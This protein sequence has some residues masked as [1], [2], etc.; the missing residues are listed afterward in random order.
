MQP[1]DLRIEPDS[2]LR[3]LGASCNARADRL[4]V[5]LRGN[6]EGEDG[7]RD[8]ENSKHCTNRKPAR[9]CGLVPGS[10]HAPRTM[11]GACRT[12]A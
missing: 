10:S 9:T 1:C 2:S 6:G 7:D 4:R 12:W 11:H 5:G 3:K 8:D